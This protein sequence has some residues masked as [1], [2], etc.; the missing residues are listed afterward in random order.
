MNGLSICMRL[1]VPAVSTLVLAACATTFTPAEITVYHGAPNNSQAVAYELGTQGRHLSS[2]HQLELQVPEGTRVCLSVLNAHTPGFTYS[3][4][5]TVDSAPPTPP[6]FSNLIGLLTAVIPGASADATNRAVELIARSAPAAARVRAAP[7]RL[8]PVDSVMKLYREPLQW[9]DQDIGTVKAAMR[10][11]LSPET[12]LPMELRTAS[13]E[14]RGL[15]YAQQVIRERDASA[16]RFNDPN[17]AATI[18]GWKQAADAVAATDPTGTASEMAGVYHQRATALLAGRNAILDA[19][20]KAPLTWRDCHAVTNGRTTLN[21]RAQARAKDDFNG[22]RDTGNVVQVIATS[23]YRRNVV[24]MVP[25]AF[26]AFPRNVTGFG[27]VNDTVREDVKYADNAAF[28]VGMMLTTSPLRFG[29]T[30]E[31]S[32]GPGIGTGVIGGDKKALSDF[33]LGGLVSWRDWLRLG[34]GYGVSLAP[35]RL[36]NG[37][38]VGK[39]LPLGQGREKLTDFIDNRRVGTWFLTFTV[40]GLKLKL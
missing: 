20:G 15:A 17:L 13:G 18:A 7:E 36:I 2:Q 19:Y 34:G 27:I 26:V 39:P 21:L 22:Q 16:G 4:A 3:L 32:F 24:E 33:F 23:N 12:L 30:N 5:A 35:S 29:P 11:S 10:L 1:A 8:S 28:R 31:W 9:L 40:T 25:L 37:A 14:N 6:D 38:A